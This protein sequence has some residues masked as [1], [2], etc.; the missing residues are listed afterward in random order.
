MPIFKPDFGDVVNILLI[1]I[2]SF[3]DALCGTGFLFVLSK[4]GDFNGSK[5]LYSSTS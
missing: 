3:K 2:L 1:L 4:H 5:Y